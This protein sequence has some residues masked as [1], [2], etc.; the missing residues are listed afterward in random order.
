[1]RLIGLTGGIASGKSTVAALLHERGATVVD[2]DAVAHEVL[3]PGGTAF[4]DVVTRFG[5]AILDDTGAVN[6]GVLGDV[7]FADPDLRGE[8]ERITHPRINALMQQRMTA[9][10]ESAAP[11]VVADIPLLFERDLDR[12][13]E[14][15]MLVYV[16]AAVQLQR[17]RD[18]DGID[19]VSARQRL[20]AQLPIDDKRGRAT[21]IIDNAGSRDA[22]AAQVDAWWRAFVAE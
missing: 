15:S 8:L 19:D 14:G 20:A 7:V 18:R 9:A 3:L 4:D 22:T 6:R 2:A 13:F 17:L 11:L 10:I 21:W 16:P 5:A 1:M 12:A